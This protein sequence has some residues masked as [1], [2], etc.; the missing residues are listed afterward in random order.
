MVR[1]RSS[2]KSGLIDRLLHA[3]SA[4]RGPIDF[5]LQYRDF[6]DAGSL[7]RLVRAIK[8]AE[9]YNRVAQSHL[10]V[11]LDQ[12]DYTAHADGHGTTRRLETLWNHEPPLRFD[13]A[14]PLRAARDNSVLQSEGSRLG[15]YS[16]GAVAKLCTH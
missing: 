14:E 13:Q 4:V 6:T 8:L 16:P 2:V 11:T 9:V 5:H 3:S 12:P 10:G 15:P 7:P 1:R